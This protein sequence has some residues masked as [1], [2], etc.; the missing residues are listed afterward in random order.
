[1]AKFKYMIAGFGNFVIV[2]SHLGGFG[3]FAGKSLVAGMK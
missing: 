3:A 2:K 1:M